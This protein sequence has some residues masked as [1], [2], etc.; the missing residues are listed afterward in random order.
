MQQP[1]DRPENWTEV[2]E[3]ARSGDPTALDTFLKLAREWLASA[4]AK[5]LSADLQSKLGASDLVQESLIDVAHDL[6]QF[7]GDTEAQCQAW[8][9]RIL[10]RHS[11]D[12][13]RRFLSAERRDARRE[14]R[15]K[16]AKRIR[17]S[18]KTPSSIARHVETDEQLE[19]AI[20]ELPDSY[21]VVIHLRHERGM[22]WEE[23]GE[24]VGVS[25]EAARKLWARA[26]KKLQ[27]QLVGEEQDVA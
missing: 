5:H 14:V 23:V 10:K 6:P 26:I 15:C 12:A 7:R 24:Q 4:A 11:A 18:I 27:Q 2:I 8:L 25:T 21:Q 13:K 22:S 9:Q 3:A 20:A 19:R 16:N 17:G 1:S